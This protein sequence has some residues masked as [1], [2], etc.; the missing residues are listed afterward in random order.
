MSKVVKNGKEIPRII[1]LIK[2]KN[3]IA[4]FLFKFCFKSTLIAEDFESAHFIAYKGQS[5]ERVVT[6]NGDLL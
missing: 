2:A 6:M 3:K 1:Q 4:S 5:R